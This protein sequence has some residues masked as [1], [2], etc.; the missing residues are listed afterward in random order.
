MDVSRNLFRSFFLALLSFPFNFL[1]PVFL[2]SLSSFVRKELWLANF[3]GKKQIESAKRTRCIAKLAVV[4]IG[5]NFQN[6]V[7]VERSTS[8]T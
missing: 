7:P 6:E 1:L 2:P 3:L 8:L 4:R 5:Q